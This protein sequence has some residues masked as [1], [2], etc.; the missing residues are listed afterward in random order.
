MAMY[1][2]ISEY[3]PQR[4]D[5]ISYSKRLWEYFTANEVEGAEKKCAILLS[6]TGAQL[7]SLSEIW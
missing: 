5:W 7:T 6:M 4:E 3:D 2:A 1:G